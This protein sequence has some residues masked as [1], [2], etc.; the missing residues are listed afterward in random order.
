MPKYYKPK[1]QYTEVKV[2]KKNPTLSQLIKAIEKEI[3]TVPFFSIEV[4][5]DTLTSNSVTVR[6]WH[7]I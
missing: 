7:D 3:P 5:M 2:E 4:L 6:A 1:T